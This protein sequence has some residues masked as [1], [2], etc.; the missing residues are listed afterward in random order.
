[1]G[2]VIRTKPRPAC[3]SLHERSR[4]VSHQ[5][6]LQ[7]TDENFQRE[8]HESS[9]PVLVD[10]WAE[11][12]APCRMLGP[13]IDSLADGYVGRVKIGKVNVDANTHVAKQYDIR[14]I[15]TVLLFVDGKVVGRFVGVRPQNEFAQALD[16]VIGSVA[17]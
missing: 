7:L 16:Q 6:V 11:W 14:S 2:I 8:V 12:C 10:F 4:T 5:A 9:M 17:T 3:G 15:P 13:T 1:M